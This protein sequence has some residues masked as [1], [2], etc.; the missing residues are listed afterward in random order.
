[1]TRTSLILPLDVANV[2]KSI[3]A[4]SKTLGYSH[5]QEKF[6]SGGRVPSS[7][8]PGIMDSLE[9]SDVA[10]LRALLLQLSGP[11]QPWGDRLLYQS[12]LYGD[13]NLAI[14]I[15]LVCEFKC[16]RDIQMRGL[17][18]ALHFATAAG[19]VQIVRF[20]L[21]FPDTEVDAQVCSYSNLRAMDIA[22]YGNDIE[23]MKVLIEAGA[24]YVTENGTTWCAFQ[25]ASNPELG[26][27]AEFVGAHYLLS[28]P[29]LIVEA[30]IISA[31][32]GT[33]DDVL[34]SATKAKLRSQLEA[35]EGDA[36]EIARK[37]FVVPILQLN[38]AELLSLLLDKFGPHRLRI[39]Q[40]SRFMSLG[41]LLFSVYNGHTNNVLPLLQA[42][43]W[44]PSDKRLGK[45][46][47]Q[48]ACER[49]YPEMVRLIDD[50]LAGD[51]PI[52]SSAAS[53]TANPYS[54]G[55]VGF[56]LWNMG[57]TDR[58]IVDAAI[59]RTSTVGDAIDWILA[60]T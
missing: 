60:N 44:N 51:M 34:I 9:R 24:D 28:L 18:T 40:S 26:K 30:N 3:A 59:A 45:D 4:W 14:V 22:S 2:R 10:T 12:I 29:K 37:Y 5:L 6:G 33:D 7:F 49:G 42:G 11:Q 47:R 57:Y 54:D 48:V 21:T 41:A 36:D 43:A 15:L 23:M 16:R 32:V 38:D 8:P 25:Y 50:H 20:L 58:Q 52:S 35:S 13:S 53:S 19:A 56:H 27:D 1:M 39:V 17:G 31:A 55:S 46:A